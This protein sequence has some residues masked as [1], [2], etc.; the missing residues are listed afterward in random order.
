MEKKEYEIKKIE[1]Q[2]TNETEYNMLSEKDFK[3]FAEGFTNA[4]N[5]LQKAFEEIN[6]YIFTPLGSGNLFIDVNDFIIDNYP[7]NYSLDEMSGITKEWV[8]SIKKALTD[9]Y[10]AHKEEFKKA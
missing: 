3:E 6:K 8:K 4:V 10:N 7:F 2:N 1:S 9:K 5:Q